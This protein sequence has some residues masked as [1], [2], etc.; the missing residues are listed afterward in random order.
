MTLHRNIYTRKDS[1]ISNNPND[2]S[3]EVGN[4]RYI[5]ELLLSIIN[6]SVQ[7]VD[8]VGSLPKVEFGE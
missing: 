7:T 4:P 2:W 5:L 3:K 1:G 8:I 6:V